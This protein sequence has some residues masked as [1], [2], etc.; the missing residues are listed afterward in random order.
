LI[1]RRWTLLGA[2]QGRTAQ[3]LIVNRVVTRE[4]DD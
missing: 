3:E 1:A 4:P 2:A